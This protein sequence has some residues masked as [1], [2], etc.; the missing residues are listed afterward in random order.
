M[1]N[2]S[3][4]LLRILFSLVQLYSTLTSQI[5]AFVRGS[6]KYK[7]ILLLLSTLLQIGCKT[8]PIELVKTGIFND[9][10]SI[11]IGDALESSFKQPKWKHFETDKKEKIVEF[12]G[13][14][15]KDLADKLDIGI[16]TADGEFDLK[17][18]NNLGIYR[19]SDLFK[20]EIWA[21]LDKLG[22]SN[23]VDIIRLVAFLSQYINQLSLTV[24]PNFQE[25]KEENLKKAKQ[26]FNLENR[27]AS[28]QFKIY[29][30]NQGFEV[31]YFNIKDT[32][33]DYKDVAD[34]IFN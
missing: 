12:T 23:N 13:L 30:D 28:I 10:P 24:S 6:L 15:S 27:P 31:S 29:K 34:Y 9:F 1:K 20:D 2:K 4:D 25:N 14:V 3:N 7:F 16:L 19:T 26:I 11:T 21:K 17:V 8:N 32:N 18:L 5:T 33:Y 22:K